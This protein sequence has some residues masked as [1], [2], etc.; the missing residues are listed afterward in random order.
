VILS[1]AFT[2]K[3]NPTTSRMWQAYSFA[4]AV[5]P[6]SYVAWQLLYDAPANALVWLRPLYF[7]VPASFALG[8]A[9]AMPTAFLLRRM[10]K[11]SGISILSA[12]LIGSFAFSVCVAIHLSG[13]ARRASTIVFPCQRE[14]TIPF[15]LSALVFWGIAGYDDFKKWDKDKR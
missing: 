1:F 5:A 12:A 15:A 11:L 6:L 7:W 14:V 10:G 4:P 2:A 9:V 8:A 3:L 13:E